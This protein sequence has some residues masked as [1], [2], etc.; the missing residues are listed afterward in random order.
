MGNIVQ[1][2][3]VAF[4]LL[5]CSAQSHQDKKKKKKIKAIDVT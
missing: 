2:S 4:A 3:C 5:Y 1:T